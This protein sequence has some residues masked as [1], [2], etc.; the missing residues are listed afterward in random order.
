[1]DT[2]HSSPLVIYMTSV[3]IAFVIIL[4]ILL[5]KIQNDGLNLFQEKTYICSIYTHST[6]YMNGPYS[7]PTFIA[8]LV[9]YCELPAEAP[10]PANT[11][12]PYERGVF[13]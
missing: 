2:S 6:L 3:F 11:H 12:T 5:S 13:F 8:I 1:M 9:K 4:T 7:D 10:N